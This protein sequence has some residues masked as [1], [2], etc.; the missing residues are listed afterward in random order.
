MLKLSQSVFEAIRKHGER[1][2]PHE[3]CGVLFGIMKGDQRIVGEVFVI[4]N[5][6]EESERYHRFL[7]TPDDYREA[8]KA[9]RAKKV[10]I[11][12]FYHSHP[13]SPS[14]AS[15]YDLD[16]AFPWFSYVIVSIIKNNYH[17]I[18]SWV[19]EN[20]RSKFNEENVVIE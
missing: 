9:A 6:F 17:D 1:A 5:Q 7:I 20:D 15:K 8:E 14:V 2:F 10:D 3:C 12:G 11:I 19:M 16:H 4:E 18:R 13:D